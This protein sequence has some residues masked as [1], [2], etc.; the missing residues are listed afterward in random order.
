MTS[1]RP[2]SGRLPVDKVAYLA[3]PGYS[4]DGRYD[5]TSTTHGLHQVA[6]I[7]TGDSVDALLL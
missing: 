6:A 3:G 4:V 7:L 2:S 1:N 5:A